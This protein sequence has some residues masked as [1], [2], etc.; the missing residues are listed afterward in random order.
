MK[1]FWSK[2]LVHSLAIQVSDGALKM[3]IPDWKTMA[4]QG[5]SPLLPHDGASSNPTALQIFSIFPLF[6]KDFLTFCFTFSGLLRPS[7]RYACKFTLSLCEN[8][9]MISAQ[10][11]C[12]CAAATKDFL[13]E[14]GNTTGHRFWSCLALH[15]YEVASIK[16][17]GRVGALLNQAG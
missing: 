13:A 16:S 15:P 14:I 7:E 8:Y 10:A 9:W 11:A 2:S 12:T 4:W 17:P 5:Q 3:T 1:F 6:E